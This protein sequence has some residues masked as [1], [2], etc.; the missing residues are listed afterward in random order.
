MSEYNACSHAQNINQMS[1]A[2]T[3]TPTKFEKLHT[4]VRIMVLNT[5]FNNISVIS[6]QSVLMM[7]EIEVLGEN[8]RPAA[9]H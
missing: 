3:K 8:H 5:T 9:S 6:G 4:E 7:E 2:M 1:V